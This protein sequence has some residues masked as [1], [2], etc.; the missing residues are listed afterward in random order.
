MYITQAE[1][2]KARKAHQCT[3]C[4]EVIGVGDTYLRWMCVET[5]DKA[6]TSKMHPECLASLQ[7]DAVGEFEYDPFSGERPVKNGRS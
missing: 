6:F 7:E 3:N 5:G 1:S 2:R 4:G